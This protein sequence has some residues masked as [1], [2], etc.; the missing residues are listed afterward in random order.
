MGSLSGGCVEEELL[1]RLETGEID[2][3]QRTLHCL[4]RRGCRERPPEFTLQRQTR[5]F[6]GAA[7]SLM[8]WMTFQDI[9]AALECGE[10]IRRD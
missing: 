5:R 9:V 4:W 8:Y 2:T 3:R 7:V 6:A 1:Q 10:N